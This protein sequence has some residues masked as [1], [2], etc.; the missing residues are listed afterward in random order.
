MLVFP[1]DR[2]VSER[3]ECHVPAR[4]N[5][6]GKAETIPLFDCSPMHGLQNLRIHLRQA[7]EEQREADMT[8]SL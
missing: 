6:G 1:A 7:D 4:V 5:D 2:R 8:Y 3:D